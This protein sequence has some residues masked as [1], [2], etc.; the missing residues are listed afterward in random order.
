[1]NQLKIYIDRQVVMY[2][3]CKTHNNEMYTNNWHKSIHFAD[4]INATGT[5][6]NKSGCPSIQYKY[7][8]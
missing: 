6:T 4:K 1:M 2:K 8:Y 7:E 3:I 5:R